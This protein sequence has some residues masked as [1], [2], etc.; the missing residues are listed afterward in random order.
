MIGFISFTQ[1]E[2][3]ALCGDLR[4][5]ADA[6]EKDG[7]VDAATFLGAFAGTA[8]RILTARAA[9][10]GIDVNDLLRVHI[11]GSLADTIKSFFRRR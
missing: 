7:I 3:D 2:K 1:A 4:L 6:I 8:W 9:V 5:A 11:E 10:F